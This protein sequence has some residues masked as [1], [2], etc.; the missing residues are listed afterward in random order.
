MKFEDVVIP[1]FVP[2]QLEVWELRVLDGVWSIVDSTFGKYAL[3]AMGS[4]ANWTVVL[5]NWCQINGVIIDHSFSS[6]SQINK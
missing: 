4:I 6:H 2:C 3:K 5:K 1:T